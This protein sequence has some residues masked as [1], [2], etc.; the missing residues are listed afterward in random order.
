MSLFGTNT[1]ASHWGWQNR[2]YEGSAPWSGAPQILTASDAAASDY[3]G[4]SVDMA[5][6]GNYCIIGAPRDDNYGAAYIFYKSG[7]VW[8]QQAKLIHVSRSS[9]D[10]F[11]TSVGINQAGDTVIVGAMN[12]DS[13]IGT[14][15]IYT[16]SGT[17]W[18][19][20]TILYPNNPTSNSY[21]GRSVSISADG[22]T[23]AVGANGVGARSAYVFTRTG[24]AWTRQTTIVGGTTDYGWAIS[25][26][27]DGNTMAV[28]ARGEVIDSTHGGTVSIYTRTA[29]TWTLQQKIFG[30]VSMDFG[31]EVSLSGDGN[32]LS[33][34]GKNSFAVTSTGPYVYIKNGSTWELQAN[35]GPDVLNQA[36]RTSLNYDGN[37]MCISIYYVSDPYLGTTTVLN[38]VYI[39]NGTNWTLQSSI[40]YG[41]LTDVEAVNALDN[42]GDDLIVGFQS[43]D[44]I[45][46]NAGAAY[47]Y[48][49]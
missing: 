45:A 22:N 24:T 3:F 46:T 33:V 1:V 23:V 38:K 18:T 36:T 30:P 27:A 35:F 43:S 15:T 10:L 2:W 21:F 16:R 7:G 49:K 31:S 37:T 12:D 48:S 41:N 5:G 42:V 44:I 34:D 4:T 32:T 9:G 25:L 26:S 13:L 14:A 47:I 8:T 39:R 19:Y 6:D 17:T 28:G 29:G 20:Q 11:G 40:D